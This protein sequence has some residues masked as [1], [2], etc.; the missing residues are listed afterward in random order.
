M[1][2]DLAQS[3][4]EAIDLMNQ[5]RYDTIFMDHMM[6]EID[7]VEATH[8]IR[9]LMPEYDD[10]A[11]IALTANAVSGAKDQYLKA[12]FK[13]YLSKPVNS[14]KLEEMI[15]NNISSEKIRTVSENDDK[16]NL[17]ETALLP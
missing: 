16:K 10:V 14:K 2:V 13:D 15:F 3:A 5:V 6:P 17:E 8:I 7:G 1:Q 12:G 11:I 9:R 4:G